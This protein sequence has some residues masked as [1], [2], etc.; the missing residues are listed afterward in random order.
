VATE[1]TILLVDAHGSRVPLAGAQMIFGRGAECN[2]RLNDNLTSRRHFVVVRT[3]AGWELKDLGSTNGTF[4]NDR[5]LR[6]EEMLP[7]AL[8]DTIKVGNTTFIVQLAQGVSVA[9]IQPPV[10]RSPVFEP[11]S[12]VVRPGGKYPRSDPVRWPSPREQV[13]Y[14]VAVALVLSA[15]ASLAIGA[16]LPW[17]QVAFVL[18]LPNLPGSDFLS[19]LAQLIPKIGP[20]VQQA[21]G[22]PA[23]IETEPRVIQGMEA[24]GPV[25]LMAAGL[26]T[27]TLVIDLV[28]RTRRSMLPGIVYLAAAVVP[29][30]FVVTDLGR[31][32]HLTGQE[33]FFGLDLSKITEVVSKFAGAKVTLL[34]GLYLTIIGLAVLM[35]AGLIRIGA[36]LF[37]RR[38]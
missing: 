25:M 17:L 38:A 10:A 1:Q 16:F 21:L 37:T 15:V 26:A 24:Y 36:P 11:H 28:L 4:L 12:A 9:P 27:V 33:V 7:L 6:P 29:S 23:V 30:V 5:R 20:V 2:V 19:Q 3:P 18:T 14:W 34:D 32:R 35:I 22:D 31:A 13:W 8:R